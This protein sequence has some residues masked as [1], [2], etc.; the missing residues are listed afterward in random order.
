[1]KKNT[2]AYHK[3]S[4]Q[5]LNVIRS[6]RRAFHE[7]NEKILYM[8]PDSRERST[9]ITQLETA[10]MWDIKAIVI[11]DPESVVEE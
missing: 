5:S 9:A 6:L 7:L 10:A 8:A 3:P 11:N 2:Y 1:M 4:Q